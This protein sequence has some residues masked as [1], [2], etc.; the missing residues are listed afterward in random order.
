MVQDLLNRVVESF[1]AKGIEPYFIG[2]RKS[3]AYKGKEMPEVTIGISETFRQNYSE[4]ENVTVTI[5]IVRWTKEDAYS[6]L[7]KRIA[8]IKVPKD[9]SDKVINSRVEKAIEYLKAE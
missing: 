8:R 3:E 2:F 1:R 6:S 5:E 7:G 4:L 9:A